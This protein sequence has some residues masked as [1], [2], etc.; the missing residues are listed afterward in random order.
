MRSRHVLWDN[1][2][3]LRKTLQVVLLLD[4]LSGLSLAIQF[5]KYLQPVLVSHQIQSG[6]IKLLQVAVELQS[7]HQNSSVLVLQVHSEQKAAYEEKKATPRL[8]VKGPLIGLLIFM[9]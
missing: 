3:R 6:F 1:I 7:Q 5:Q 4:G 8:V 2:T 9:L